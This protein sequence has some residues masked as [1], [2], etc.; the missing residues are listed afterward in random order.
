MTFNLIG[1]PAKFAL[2]SEAMGKEVE[3]LPLMEAASLAVEAVT[4]V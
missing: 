3:G 4:S 1:N 2:I